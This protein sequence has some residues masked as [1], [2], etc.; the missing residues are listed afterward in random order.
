[1][2]DK[3]IQESHGNSWEDF[4]QSGKANPSESGHKLDSSK[5]I[6]KE[7]TSTGMAEQ[8]NIGYAYMKSGNKRETGRVSRKTAFIHPYGKHTTEKKNC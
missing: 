4:R 6:G 3:S 5:K 8:K 7:C 2:N 1:M